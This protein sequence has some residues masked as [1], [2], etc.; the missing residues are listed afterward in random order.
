MRSTRWA[1]TVGL[2]A[3]MLLAAGGTAQA[4]SLDEAAQSRSEEAKPKKSVKKTPAKP[5]TF[6]ITQHNLV[7]DP[8]ILKIK[9]GDKVVWTNKESDDTIH[10]VVQSNGSEINSPDIPPNTVFE[11]T[12]TEP[13]EWTIVCRFHPD[14]FMNIDVAGK[15]GAK[16][17]SGGHTVQPPPPATGTPGEPTVP[18]VAGLPIAFDPPA[19]RRPG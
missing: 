2:C 5:K 4:A 15:K 13:S 11:W 8:D 12:F 19:N 18:G 14:M 6:K 3:A 1:R 10:S 7:F 16:A 9:P 17:H